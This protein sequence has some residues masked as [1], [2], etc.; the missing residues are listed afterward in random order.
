MKVGKKGGKKKKDS[1]KRNHEFAKRF[2]LS[3]RR[4]SASKEQVIEGTGKPAK[5]GER[6]QM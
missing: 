6:R 2:W 1:L 3:V 4:S 5:K